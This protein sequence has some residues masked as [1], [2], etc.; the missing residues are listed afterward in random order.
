MSEIR[1]IAHN[2]AWQIAG[3]IISTGLGL[4]AIAIMTR[5]L[6]VEQFGWYATAVGFLQFIGIFTDFGFTVITSSMLSEPAHDKSKLLGNL[7]TWRMTTAIITQGLIPL[8]IFFFPY[9][10]PIKWAVIIMA[11]SFIG[12]SLNQVLIAYYQTKLALH[13]QAIGEVLGRVVLVA[14]LALV[15]AGHL[16]FLPMMVVITL[17]SFAYTGYL[18]YRAEPIRWQ[19]DRDIGKAIFKKIWPVALAVIFNCFYLQGDRLILPLFATQTEV[20]LYGAAYRV[21]DIALQISAMLMGMLL[22]L[23]AFAWSR[24]LKDDFKKQA[25]RGFDLMSLFIIPIVA[26][27]LALAQPIMTFVA[28]AD[29]AGSG[30]FLRIQILTMLGILFG[31]VFGHINLAIGRQ[32]YSLWIYVLDAILAVIAYFIFIPLL[33]GVGAAWVRVGSEIFAGVGLMLM[34]GIFSGFWPRLGA[35]AKIILASALMGWLVWWLQPLNI[36]LSVFIGLAVYAVLVLTFK[37]ISR[38]TIREVLSRDK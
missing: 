12:V 20:G 25:Q 3:K 33:G 8:T 30:A 19:F 6:G 1:K 13:I 18:W 34:A 23:I 21:I 11:L 38:Q 37:V 32:K 7:F 14:G 10:A 36:I 27:A 29:F 24:G 16:G 28:G 17:G 2:T 15:S 26:G 4:V 5:S 9:P 31:T 22:P 35:F